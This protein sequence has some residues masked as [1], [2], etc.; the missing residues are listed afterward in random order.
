MRTGPF[1]DEKVIGLLNKYFIP[2]YAVN[3]DYGKDGTQPGE[4]K[5][6]Y[7]RIYRAALDAKGPAG[8]VH[9][10]LLSPDGKYFNSMHVAKAV[11]KGR[12]EELLKQTVE[13]LKIEGGKPVVKPAPQSAPPKAQDG[14]L[15][16]HLTARPLK[17]GGSWDG[18]SENWIVLNADEVKKILPTS[19][20]EKGTKWGFD[21][22]VVSKLLKP[23]YPVTENNDLSTNRIDR[24]EL[25]ATVVSVEDGV[26]RTRIEGALK[27]KH[28]FYP[29]REDNNV[30]EAT[31][32]G[33]LDFD[34][35]KQRVRALRVVTD[36][37]TYGGGTFGVALRSTP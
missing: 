19:K 18:V 25:T 14:A 6:E 8:T 9:V 30:V 4:E 31:L 33:Y 23:F 15:I 5:A 3:E 24:Q 27:M 1:S 22:D 36:S 11:E 13:K 16:L 7:E 21:K 2:V 35:A 26:V 12:L 34:P 29:H 10:Y 20:V 17:G 32:V 28:T 37:A